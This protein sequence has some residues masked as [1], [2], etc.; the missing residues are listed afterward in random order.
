M[1]GRTQNYEQ[2]LEW[3]FQQI[4]MYQRQGKAAYKADLSATE[5]LDEYMGHP[6]RS[7]RTIHVGGTNGKGSVAHMLASVLQSAGYRTGL[8]TSPHLNDFR[9]RIKVD[10]QMVDRDFVISFMERN[11]EHFLQVRPSFFEMTVAMAFDYFRQVQVDVAVIEVGLGGRLDSTNIID[12][13][14]SVITN[15]SLDHTQFLGDTVEQIAREKAGIIKENKPVVV[16]ESDPRTAGIF[17]E[18]ALAA[19]AELFFADQDYRIT[20]EEGG[21]SENPCY[22]ISQGQRVIYNRLCTDLLGSYQSRNIVTTLR[23]VDVLNGL[24]Y[25]LAGEQ[26]RK[27]LSNVGGITGFRGRWFIL[28]NNPLIICDTA[29]NEAGLNINVREAQ[30]LNRGRLHFVLSFVNDK[31]LDAILKIFPTSARYY[32]TRASIPRALEEDK[33]TEMA[34]RYGLTGQCYPVAGDA[35][36]AARDQARQEDLIYVGGSTF[37]VSELI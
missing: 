12:P 24:G 3:M 30:R 16:G 34:A 8:Y 9:E 32:F 36:R 23:A 15:I 33:L 21:F 35:L 13:E 25:A 37:L 28:Q 11:Q 26:V 2:V 29:H 22:S 6:H 5:A 10:G 19:H 7:F 17:R 14:L 4:P 20:K 31:Q 18:K 1:I 27:G